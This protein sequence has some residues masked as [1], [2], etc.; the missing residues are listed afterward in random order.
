MKEFSFNTVVWGTAWYGDI[1][2]YAVNHSSGVYYKGNEG[3]VD[4]T[5]SQ[6]TKFSIYVD[7]DVVIM[8]QYDGVPKHTFRSSDSHITFPDW[9][10]SGGT[11]RVGIWDYG[12]GDGSYKNLK[13]KNYNPWR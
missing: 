10:V 4:P 1:L 5:R 13:V 6:W 8:Y 11:V 7:E 3:P 9:A 12:D 2:R